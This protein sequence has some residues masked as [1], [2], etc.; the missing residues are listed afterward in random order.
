MHVLKE[1][2]AGDVLAVVSQSGGTVSF[3]DAGSDAFLGDVEVPMEPHEL[4][5]DAERRLLWCATAYKSG[6]YH[7][8]SGR[9]SELTAIDPDTRRVVAVID[10]ALEHAPHGL[11]LDARRGL[12]YVSV[13]GGPDRPG[14]V[15]VVDAAARKAVGRIDTGA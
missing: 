12:L 13:E 7:A 10:L 3:F 6:Y 8:N 14:G 15:V 4:C 1:E 2:R 5:F 9:A 11:A